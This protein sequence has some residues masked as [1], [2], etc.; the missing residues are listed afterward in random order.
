M[1]FH[2]S[3]LL[4]S[5]IA[6]LLLAS[7]QT[8]D[9]DPPT[10]CTPEGTASS[11]L[12]E[13][14]E[15]LAGTTLTLTER[16]CDNQG[17]S[18]VR[19]DIHNA[20][21]HAHEAGA[22]EAGL[23]LHSGTAWEVLEIVSASGTEADVSLAVEVPLTVRGVWDLVV[24]I[25]DAEG[26]VSSDHVTQLHLENDHLPA[27]SVAL[28]NGEDPNTW[29]GEPVWA[30]GSEATLEG[31]V[32]DA[33]GLNTVTLALVEEASETTLWEV[34]WEA[35]SE[36]VLAFNEAFTLPAG[37]SG[38][39]HVEMRATDALGNAVETGFHVEVE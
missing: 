8:T 33:D 3:T 24:S 17:L 11:V 37:V 19:W 1:N 13:E 23:V 15:A 4:T 18:E 14:I 28:V 16:L 29:E 10:L 6:A 30:A 21:D 35:V 9:L 25:V 2:F 32:T 20:A 38:E 34:S 12:A 5:A 39:C 27:F 22:E 26:N 36:N 31:A 7:C